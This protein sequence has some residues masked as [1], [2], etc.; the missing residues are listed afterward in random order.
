MTLDGGPGEPA[1]STRA[2]VADWLPGIR[3]EHEDDGGLEGALARP[4]DMGSDRH[5]QHP[6]AA[7][8]AS[9]SPRAPPGLLTARPRRWGAKAFTIR[10]IGG[11]RG[12]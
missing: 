6:H 5:A 12:P 9:G 7:P 3:D 11:S 2:R 8:G 4:P 10:R 1:T